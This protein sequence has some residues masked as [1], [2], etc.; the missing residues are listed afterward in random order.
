MRQEIDKGQKRY[1]KLSL[2]WEDT[3]NCQYFEVT[4]SMLDDLNIRMVQNYFQESFNL[5]LAKII[6]Q[7]RISHRPKNIKRPMAPPP[8]IKIMM[9]VER[10]TTCRQRN[11]ANTGKVRRLV[12]ITPI[13]ITHYPTSQ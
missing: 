13:N 10:F 9:I 11:T 2:L 12:K 3:E 1:N 4:K 8:R 7:M 6:H 5:D